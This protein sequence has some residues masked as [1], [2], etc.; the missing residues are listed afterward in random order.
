MQDVI[1][2]TP[3]KQ[4]LVGCLRESG[5][6]NKAYV[7]INTITPLTVLFWYIEHGGRAVRAGLDL[8]VGISNALLQVESDFLQDLEC[9]SYIML[10]LHN[11]SGL[12]AIILLGE[13]GLFM[14]DVV[15]IT[16]VTQHLLI[17]FVQ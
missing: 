14:K 7:V 2:V 10:A 5:L 16:Q 4:W 9:L 3:I 8:L 13:G 6:A 15:C 12:F 1:C 17:H 11:L